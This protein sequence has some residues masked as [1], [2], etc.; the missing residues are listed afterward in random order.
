MH[1]AYLWVKFLH[2]AAAAVFLGWT[3]LAPF[4]LTQALR[5]TTMAG[6]P[7]LRRRMT[8]LLV[9]AVAGGL[10]L[11]WATG[12]LMARVLSPDAF[13]LPWLRNSAVLAVVA[14]VTWLAVLL[15][16]YRR[17]IAAQ[18]AGNSPPRRAVMVFRAVSVGAMAAAMASLWMM[19][20]RPI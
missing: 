16:W 2:T 10:A 5:V 3:M 1:D 12:A 13:A 19:V 17:M 4:W 6:L 8:V 14:A 20:V 9:V 11:L 15:P 7:A 18:A